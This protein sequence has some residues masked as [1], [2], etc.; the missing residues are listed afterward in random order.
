MRTAP[1]TWGGFAFLA[2]LR[3]LSLSTDVT[4]QVFLSWVTRSGSAEPCPSGTSDLLAQAL[5]LGPAALNS[6][7]SLSGAILKQRSQRA[8]PGQKP[9]LRRRVHSHVPGARPEGPGLPTTHSCEFCHSPGS[10]GAS[11]GLEGKEGVRW[12]RSGHPFT[13]VCTRAACT[14][15]CV[16][17]QRTVVEQALG[18]LQQAE[19]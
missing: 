15:T 9:A 4:P 17:S 5:V 8:P 2:F 18:Q 11:R 3:P 13:H 14:H 12:H 1:L 6:T 10:P 19:H 16:S 7:A